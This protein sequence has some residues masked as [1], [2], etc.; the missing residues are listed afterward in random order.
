MIPFQTFGKNCWENI[1]EKVNWRIFV[2]DGLEVCVTCFAK[3]NCALLNNQNKEKKRSKSK[4]FRG[5]R[6]IPLT[7]GNH[8]NES[9]PVDIFIRAD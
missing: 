4:N 9:L 8:N 7:D 6:N 3:E 1:L 5:I 2:S